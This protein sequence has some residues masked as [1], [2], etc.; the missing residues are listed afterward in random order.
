MKPGLW[1]GIELDI[2][3]TGKNDGSIKGFRYFTCPTDSG[4]FVL[5]SKATAVEAKTKQTP[6]KPSLFRRTKSSQVTLSMTKSTPTASPILSKKKNTPNLT[7]K[8]SSNTQKPASTKQPALKESKSSASPTASSTTKR[9]SFT[10]NRT[11]PAT[12]PTPSLSAGKKREKRHSPAL[13]VTP[14]ISP[15]RVMTDVKGRCTLTPKLHRPPSSPS[16]HS[17]TLTKSKSTNTTSSNPTKPATAQPHAALKKSKVV[18]QAQLQE[19]QAL[20]EQSDQ[21]RQRLSDEMN[22]KEAVWERLVTSKESFALQVQEREQEIQQLRKTLGQAQ[23]QL[24][25][26]QQRHSQMEDQQAC[27]GRGFYFSSSGATSNIDRALSTTTNSSATALSWMQPDSF[28]NIME[29]QYQQRIEK[30][31]RLVKEWQDDAQD[32]HNKQQTEKRQHAAQVELL[33]R[34]LND[35]DHAIATIEKETAA[36][37]RKAKEGLHLLEATLATM[38]HTHQEQ[39]N[40]KEMMIQHLRQVIQQQRQAYDADPLV[41]FYRDC[42]PTSF[43]MLPTIYESASPALTLYPEDQD[44]TTVDN[45]SAISS[46]SSSSGAMASTASPSSRQRLE[47]QLDI[48]TRALDDMHQRHKQ[49]VAENEQLSDQI[50]QMMCVSRSAEQQSAQLQ[51]E[52]SNEVSDKR[53]I[54]AERDAALE[55]RQH[56]EDQMAILMASNNRLEAHIKQ[57]QRRIH[58]LESILATSLQPTAATATQACMSYSSSTYSSFTAEHDPSMLALSPVLDKSISQPAWRSAS[59]SPACT[60]PLVNQ[61]PSPYCE[62]CECLGHDVLAC[63]SFSEQQDTPQLYCVNCDVFGSHATLDCPC[64]DETF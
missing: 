16:Q 15:R 12:P 5:S 17:P 55:Q 1:I 44:D 10:N 19:M 37:K 61:G 23:L 50:K 28:V 42:S 59:T 33:R 35:R 27:A 60:G 40:D 4:L 34:E 11:V 49:S 14:P 36:E 13:P 24:D 54:M 57:E 32:S 2:Q 53:R 6:T 39:M 8:G 52:L 26:Y 43:A 48:S 45:D 21:E 31:E 30:L 20:L 63:T 46:T 22:N 51:Q 25:E 64:S 56:M 41:S 29:Q 62:I 18:T 58:E 47:H 9:R 7:I 3:G 38:E